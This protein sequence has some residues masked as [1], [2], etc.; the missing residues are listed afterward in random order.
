ME[1]VKAE[2]ES[3][4]DEAEL[5]YRHIH[6]NDG[7]ARNEL[8]N[9]YMRIARS[10]AARL[11][12]LRPIDNLDFGDYMQ[13]AVIGLIQS[14]DRF[15][16]ERNITFSTYASHR[17]RGAILN[18]LPKTNEYLAQGAYR[19]RV[20]QERLRSLDQGGAATQS[21]EKL[22]S[23][24]VDVAIGLALGYMLEDSGML[25][26]D[27]A[28][29]K[30]D[31]YNSMAMNRLQE[32]LKMIVEVLPEKEKAIIKY[33]YFGYVNFEDIAELL[34]LSKGRVSQLHQQ[35]LQLIRQAFEELG[36]F[37]ASY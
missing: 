2:K 22:F 33:H 9:R 8:I 7:S 6:D 32:Q 36:R 25:Q 14:V 16:P 12:A 10:I 21:G 34:G 5:W 29:Q 1:K 30:S 20:R 4:S 37:D 27:S 18:S 24:M 19:K 31:P 13:H 11:F 17:I 26:E 23:E 15:N 35:A 3:P 28:D